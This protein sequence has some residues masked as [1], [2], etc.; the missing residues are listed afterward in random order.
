[1]RIF[2][3]HAVLQLVDLGFM[4]RTFDLH[5]GRFGSSTIDCRSRTIPGPSSMIDCAGAAATAELLL[6]IGVHDHSVSLC[7]IVHFSNCVSSRSLRSSSSLKA[8]SSDAMRALVSRAAFQAHQHLGLVNLFKTSIAVLAIFKS[9]CVRCTANAWASRCNGMTYPLRSIR[10]VNCKFVVGRLQVLLGHRGISLE[11]CLKRLLGTLLIFFHRD[12]RRL[13]NL[14]CVD[15]RG[16]GL[17]V[18]DRLSVELLSSIKEESRRANS[19][20]SFTCV[21]SLISHKIVLPPCTSHLMSTLCE[22]LDV[23]IFSDRD[24]RDPRA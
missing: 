3:P 12:F 22:R 18:D 1:M 10:S 4:H 6:F 11:G 14:L 16:P 17:F 5:L 23:A 19:S 13:E 24:G 2:G 20:P 8:A 21:P 15:L 7:V 9:N